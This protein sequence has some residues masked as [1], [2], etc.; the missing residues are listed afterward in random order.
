MTETKPKPTFQQK[1]MWI[2]YCKKCDTYYTDGNENLSWN[3][4]L[5]KKDLQEAIED[6]ELR[7]SCDD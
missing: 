1:K 2:A 7:C 3:C 4:E 5:R 6:G